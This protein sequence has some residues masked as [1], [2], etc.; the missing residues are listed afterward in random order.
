[1]EEEKKSLDKGSYS[2][3]KGPK[4]ISV[5]K[6]KRRIKSFQESDQP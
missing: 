3:Q 2:L 5:C 1:M 6:K 4:P